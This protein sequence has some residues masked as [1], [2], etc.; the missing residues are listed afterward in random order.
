[1]KRW[2]L[3]ASLAVGIM[4]IALISAGPNRTIAPTLQHAASPG[5]LSKPHAFLE[6]NCEAC[7]TAGK[8]ADSAKCIACHANNEALLQR[9]PTAFHA[10]IGSCTQC[11]AEHQGVNQRPVQMNHAALAHIGLQ[12]LKGAPP[13]SESEK[14]AQV[15]RAYIRQYGDS[16][17]VSLPL[18]HPSLTPEETALN[19]AACHAT[20]DV[21]RQLFGPNCAACHNTAKWT[22]P[23]FKHPSPQSMNCA[24]C[25][26]APPSHYMEH[27]KMIS[28][29][30]A[31]QPNATVMQCYKCHQTTS[32]NDIK[33]VG[34][35]KHH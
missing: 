18:S 31:D 8:G 1:M 19:C 9:Q 26:Q 25:H 29:K 33:R 13:G 34:W 7:H 10:T 24:Q 2:F 15:I 4:V 20:K 22:I 27:F 32:W 17:P 35:Y 11:H 30:I 5:P 6:K 3:Y 12:K 16:L 28:M 23:E 21:H 14:E